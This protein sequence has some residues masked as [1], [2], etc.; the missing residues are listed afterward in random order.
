VKGEPLE[1]HVWSDLCSLL[2]DPRRLQSELARHQTDAPESGEA[3]AKQQLRVHDLRVRLDRMIDAYANGLIEESEFESRI[4]SLRT[5]HDRALA[6]LASQ[7]GELAE[8]TDVAAATSTLSTLAT[9]VEQNLEVATLDLKR[10]LLTLLIKRIEIHHDEIRI[11]YKVPQNPFVP[12][13]ANRGKLQHR[14]QLH[15]IAWDFSPVDYT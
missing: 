8:A 2:Q 6:A 14:L 3:L 11:V 9:E 10:T 4:G 7:R 1:Y 13:L 15:A 5:Q 12:S